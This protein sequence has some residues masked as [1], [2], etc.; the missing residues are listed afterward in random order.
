[1]FTNIKI[2]YKLYGGFAAALVLLLIVAFKT[3]S[4]LHSLQNENNK[5]AQIEKLKQELQQR[6]TDHYKWVV[7][8][9][10]SIIRQEDRLTLEKNDH[11]CALGRWLYGDG[12]AQTVKNFP[13]LATVV[14]N[15]E[16]PHA[17]L[18]K[19]ALV[20][21]DELKSGGD[22]SWISTLYQQNTVPALH[23]V[24]KGLNEAIAFL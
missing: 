23:K 13:E 21:E 4:T 17:A 9:N 14:Q 18:H 10:E 6:I 3:Q 11:A 1:M 2:K 24:K 16:A 5:V 20:I 8:L 19:S 7:S 15:L 12:R 22:I